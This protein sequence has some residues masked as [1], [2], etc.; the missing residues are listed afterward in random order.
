VPG[1]GIP[2]VRVIVR[3][4]LLDDEHGFAKTHDRV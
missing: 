1:H 2:A 3:A 4:L